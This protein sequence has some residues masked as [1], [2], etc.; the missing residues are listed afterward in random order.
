MIW[1]EADAYS[2]AG[3]AVGDFGLGPGFELSEPESDAKF[4]AYF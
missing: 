1:S 4:R 2:E 3:C